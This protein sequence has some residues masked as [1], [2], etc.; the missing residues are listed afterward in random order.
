[1]AVQ[2]GI[3]TQKTS[4]HQVRQPGRYL[5]DTGLLFEVNRTVF[6]PTGHQLGVASDG[7][8]VLEYNLE[9]PTFV[10]DMVEYRRGEQ[11]LRHFMH[12]FGRSIGELRRRLVGFV[13]QTGPDVGQRRMEA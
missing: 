2:I 9:Q 1:M 6:H 10:F 8:L 5:V 12:K 11:K 13:V 3:V 4:V 7:S